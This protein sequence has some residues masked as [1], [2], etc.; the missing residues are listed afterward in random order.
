MKLEILPTAIVDTREQRP[1]QFQNLPVE[2]GTLTTGDYSVKGLEDRVAVE[3]KDMD[4]LLA[5][6]GHGRER[7][8][9]ELHRLQSYRFRLLIVEA[10]MAELEAGLSRSKLQPAHVLGALAAWI[11]QYELP[12]MLVTGHVVAAR[13]T[14]RFL[15]QA[16]RTVWKESEALRKMMPML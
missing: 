14:E 8:K 10:S 11:A 16:A 3:R 9:R 13:F 4:D 7:F 1:F 12:I 15:Y 5:C 6:C 2:R